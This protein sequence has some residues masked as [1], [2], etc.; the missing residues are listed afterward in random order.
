M[1]LTRCGKLL[2]KWEI[3]HKIF[4][5]CF[6][7]SNLLNLLFFYLGLAF[8][9]N[10]ARKYGFIIGCAVFAVVCGVAFLYT[11][12]KKTFSGCT[13]LLMGSIVLFFSLCYAT[14]VLRF[15]F[16][17]TILNNLMKFIVFSLPAFMA[18]VCGAVWKAETK[19]FSTLETVSVVAFPGALIYLNSTLFDSLP[20]NYGADLG[21]MGYMTLAYTFMPFLL[22]HMICFSE[23][24]KLKNPLN[25][26]ILKRPQLIRGIAIGVYWMAIIASA[27][28]GAYVCVAVF[29]CLLVTFFF[30][31]Y[32]KGRKRVLW[33]STFMIA[34]LSFNLF[35]YSPAGWYRISR[36]NLFL[37]GL[38]QGEL[39]TSKEDE[40]V[41][42]K[43]DELVEADG[44][45]Q[46][47]N[48]PES[49]DGSGNPSDTGDSSGNE[50]NP[51]SDNIT[52]E[53]LQIR[54]RGTLFTL[55]IK[56]FMKS[57]ITGMGPMGY[58]LKYGLYPHSVV[59]ELFCETGVLGAVP[60]ILI[61]LYV[62]CKLWVLG[63][64]N[65]SIFFIFLFLMVYAV[66]VNISGSLWTCSPL[67]C[68]LGYGIA[69]EKQPVED[70]GQNKVKMATPIHRRTNQH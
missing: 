40:E 12:Y 54:S 59:L 2:E 50:K 57:P 22:T 58:T 60:L 14:A 34:V 21:I 70:I 45:E 30:I 10:F 28:R 49:P 8:E 23:K 7:F 24:E 32:T 39:V 6:V 3:P 13:Y 65:K 17:A 33:M 18:G 1:W 35:V 20:W 63:R 69:I 53:N 11:F 16:K 38:F 48:R 5:L 62:I 25:G 9:E 44:K 15:G 67:L 41:T 61:L 56:E 4:P 68:A 47:T 43:I 64:K 52:E 51:S 55:S 66:Q 36:A 27:T 42:E 46:V 37:E 31:R 29:C 26:K 19:F